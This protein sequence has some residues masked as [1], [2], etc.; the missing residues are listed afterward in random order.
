MIGVGTHTGLAA[1]LATGDWTIRLETS[2]GRRVSV[3]RTGVTQSVCDGCPV[4]PARTACCQILDACRSGR[5]VAVGD[6]ITM[7]SVVSSGA[8][9]PITGTG[10]IWCVIDLR[11]K[12]ATSES[13][14][15][16]APRPR[17]GYH[18]S[19]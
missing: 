3:A 15:S 9:A 18:A 4:N 16:S 8:L 6:A 7:K 1:A 5:G 17:R 2:G 13:P 19:D 12:I 11:L 10:G 14:P